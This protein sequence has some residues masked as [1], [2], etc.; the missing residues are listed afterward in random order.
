M[1]VY[2]DAGSHVGLEDRP[3]YY[4]G[5]LNLYKLAYASQMR[6]GLE[7][8]KEVESAKERFALAVQKLSAEGGGVISI[9]YHPCE[10]VHKEFWDAVNFRSG[11]NPPRA[12]WKRPPAKTPEESKIAYQNFEQY[13][14]FMHRFQEVRFI[15]ASEAAKLYPDKA[16]GREFNQADLKRIAEGVKEDV[17]FQRYPDHTLSASEVFALLNEYVA[18]RCAG[19]KRELIALTDTPY[20]PG[21]VVI[22]TKATVTTDASQFSRTATDVAD[23]LRKQKRIPTS[24]WLGSQPAPPEMY[25]QALAKVTIDL[26][27]D[28]PIPDVVELPLAKLAAA[29]YVADD[30][31]RHLWGWIIFPTGFR[32]PAMMELAKRQAW[33][34]KPALLERTAE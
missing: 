28:K 34:L 3:C 20:G 21:N 6:T 22:P 14:Q 2:L 8:P 33:T 4:G 31:P 23:F 10:F 7:N 26:L 1:E 15:T 19:R 25:L 16:H 12:K 29:K 30:D 17:S 5:V 27:E 9:Y 11:A 18:E 32:A 13:V 24:V